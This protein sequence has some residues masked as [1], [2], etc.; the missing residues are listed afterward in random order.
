MIA[1]PK[2]QPKISPTPK[3]VAR[4]PWKIERTGAN[5]AT[6]RIVGITRTWECD[7][8]DRRCGQARGLS[9]QPQEPVAELH[10]LAFNAAIT[11]SKRP[12]SSGSSMSGGIA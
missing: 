12:P 11:L 1:I 4:H 3:A 6:V 10:V 8:E 9:L 5:V 2:P 7:Q